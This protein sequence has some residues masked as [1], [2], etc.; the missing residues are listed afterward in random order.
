MKSSGRKNMGIKGGGY[1]GY[2]QEKKEKGFKRLIEANLI[3]VHFRPV[4]NFHNEIPL[5]N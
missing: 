1:K 3:N 5:Y 4:W 2:R